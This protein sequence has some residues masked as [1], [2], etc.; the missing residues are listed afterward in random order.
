M[1][2][3]QNFI[4]SAVNSYR[5]CAESLPGI[6]LIEI[7]DRKRV[8]IENHR[9]IVAYGCKEMLVK[10]RY[11]QIRISGENL[12]ISKMSRE[13]LIIVGHIHSISLHGRN[14]NGFC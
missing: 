7:C 11:G 10:V 1:K 5:L 12:K 14:E 6:P 3:G 9:G 2:H 8:L 13:R 4:K